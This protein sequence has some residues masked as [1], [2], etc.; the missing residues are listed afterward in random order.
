MALERLHTQLVE[1][2]AE[3]SAALHA[4]LQRISELDRIPS[5]LIPSARLDEVVAEKDAR[6]QVGLSLSLYVRTPL[7]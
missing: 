5:T 7:S 3:H 2:K 4:A 1:D 6:N